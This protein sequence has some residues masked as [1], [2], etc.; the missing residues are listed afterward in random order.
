MNLDNTMSVKCEPCKAASAKAAWTHLHGPGKRPVKTD[1]WGMVDDFGYL[2]T[3]EFE[4]YADGV[5]DLIRCSPFALSI[6]DMR[7]QLG[8]GF[9]DRQHADALDYLM[10]SGDIRERPSGS[11]TR[12]EPAVRHERTERTFGRTSLMLPGSSRSPIAPSFEDRMAA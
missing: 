9:N 12:Y 5:L 3:P 8:D 1:E 6:G 2:D 7:R 10:A 11:L 4:Q